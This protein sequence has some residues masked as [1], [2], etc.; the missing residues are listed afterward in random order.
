[1]LRRQCRSA[2]SR[3]WQ[4]YDA[5]PFSQHR[6]TFSCVATSVTWLRS[7][8]FTSW[9]FAMHTHVLE[10]L[11]QS[12]GSGL[13]YH[14]VYSAIVC[15]HRKSRCN[16][17]LRENSGTFRTLSITWIAMGV[18]CSFGVDL[19]QRACSYWF[20]QSLPPGSF[21]LQSTSVA[22][23][24]STHWQARFWFWQ[25]FSKECVCCLHQQSK[26]PTLNIIWCTL[27][28]AGQ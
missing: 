14:G 18:F 28:A 13:F 8:R 2:S 16:A 9:V 22:R 12:V 27:G 24:S 23:R 20:Y 4:F 25:T 26:S 17:H 10:C 15:M 11:F 6:W 19:L 1:M 7:C 5:L 3:H 21:E